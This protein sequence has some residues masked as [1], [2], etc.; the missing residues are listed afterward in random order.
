MSMDNHV[1]M[2]AHI[3]VVCGV[4]Y[5]T[6][7]ILL[8]TKYHHDRTGQLAPIKPIKKHHVTG[9]GVCPKHQQQIDEGFVH[10]I[11]MEANPSS[12]RLTSEQFLGSRRTG[13]MVTIKREVLP[14]ILQDMD[15]E[16]MP[17]I[18]ACEPGTVA[19]IAAIT[20]Q[21]MPTANEVKS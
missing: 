16:N 15:V 18:V 1:G 11:E 14:D 12:D 17:P 21:E 3:C 7:A 8:A 5:D 10:F 19:R 2:E 9:P 4:Q 13:L 20:G 6:G